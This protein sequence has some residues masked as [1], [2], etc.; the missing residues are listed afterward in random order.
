MSILEKM[1]RDWDRRARIDPRYWVAATQEADE[2]SYLESAERDVA[3][4]LEGLELPATAKVLDLGCGIGR[5]SGLLTERFAEIVGVDV[6]G[7]MIKTARELHPA[8]N[9]RFETVNGADLAAFDDGHFDLVF[10]Y[11]V[12]P[13]LPADVVQS[14]FHEV[15]RVLVDGGLFRFQFWIGRDE[16]KA[17]DDTLS[18]RVYAT[19]V[20]EQMCAAAGL[21]PRTVTPIDYFDPVLKLSPVWV[22]AFK[23]GAPGSTE[24]EERTLE[25]SEEET[26]LEYQLLVY[27]AVKHGERGETRDAERVLEQAINTAPHRPEAYVQWATHRVEADDA[28]GALKIFE[29]LTEK[30]PDE[31]VGWIYVAQFAIGMELWPQARK[32]LDRFDA[33]DCG[34]EEFVEHAAA[35]REGLPPPPKRTKRPKTRLKKK[36]R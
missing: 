1:R 3:A 34:D 6:S 26:E 32:A 8:D 35:L 20:F 4:L 27:L 5:L 29:V 28:A 18:I 31:P 15:S 23:I 33:L 11:S 30:A 25:G 13:H 21:E 17:A 14:Y 10:S 19:E 16:G 24:L 12:L 2:E 7:E 22:D 9:L 36:K